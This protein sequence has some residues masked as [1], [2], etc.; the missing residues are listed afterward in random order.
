[1]AKASLKS[2]FEPTPKTIRKIG[3]LIASFGNTFGLSSGLT[4]YFE[5]DPIMSKKMMLLGV[6]A[7]VCGW[8]GKEITNFFQDEPSEDAGASPQ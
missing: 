4:G 3:L 2:Y 6:I 7:C 8:L 5:N 1:M